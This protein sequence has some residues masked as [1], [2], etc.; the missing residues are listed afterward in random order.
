MESFA[1]TS[2]EVLAGLGAGLVKG[3]TL[4]GCA[5]CSV[6]VLRSHL[7]CHLDDPW[8]VD[9]A[10]RAVTF[11]HDANDPG[12]VAFAILWRLDLSTE[13]SCLFTWETD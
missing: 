8:L 4:G 12:L 5:R 10:R 9:D 1:E 2:S 7:W 11:L 13:A 6:D 3:L